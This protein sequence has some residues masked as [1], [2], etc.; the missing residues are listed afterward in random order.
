[1]SLKVLTDRKSAQLGTGGRV[2]S[3]S[4]DADNLASSL[5]D[6]SETSQ[7]VPESGLGD[8][9]VGGKDG[10]AVHVRGWVGLGRQMAPDD[11]VFLKTTYVKEKKT[12]VCRFCVGVRL[13]QAR[14]ILSSR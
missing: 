11:L 7:E 2:Y 12:L 5:L 10:H 6:L 4:L 3:Y 1:M 13:L 9:L 14:G 8:R